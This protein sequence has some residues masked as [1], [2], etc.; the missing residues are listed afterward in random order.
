MEDVRKLLDITHQHLITCVSCVDH[1]VSGTLYLVKEY[2]GG[3][4]SA[5]IRKCK[6][7]NSFVDEAFIWKIIYQ[8]GRA[9]QAM[10]A[11]GPPSIHL[12]LTPSGVNLDEEGNVKLDYWL[13]FRETEAEKRT[14]RG[15]ESGG[16]VSHWGA[17]RRNCCHLFLS[18]VSS[19]PT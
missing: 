3:G 4:V 7:T 18:Q 17:V 1:R 14:N 15:K 13:I 11:R 6:S 12:D 19:T 8:V 5:L 16:S 9:V 2:I 10:Y